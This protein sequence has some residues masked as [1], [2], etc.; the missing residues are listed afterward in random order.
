MRKGRNRRKIEK[1]E[2]DKIN[3]KTKKCDGERKKK[4]LKKL[5]KRILCKVIY[6][7]TE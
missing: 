5:R 6:M 3:E 7:I 1:A 2:T 4:T